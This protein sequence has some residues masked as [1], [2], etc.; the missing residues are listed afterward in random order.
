MFSMELERMFALYARLTLLSRTEEV[1]C[2]SSFV[3]SRL[4]TRIDCILFLGLVLR[5]Q[6]SIHAYVGTGVLPKPETR[7]HHI[8]GCPPVR[9]LRRYRTLP[10]DPHLSPQFRASA[11]RKLRCHEVLRRYGLAVKA[12]AVQEVLHLRL[13]S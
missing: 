2:T 10:P 5:G 6:S 4:L 3:P 7:T 1:R 12:L 13:G 9:F 8:S 11:L